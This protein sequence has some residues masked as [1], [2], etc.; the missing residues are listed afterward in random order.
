[1]IAV[2]SPHLD[3]GVFSCGALLAARPGSVVVTA[4][5]GRRGVALPPKWE[6]VTPWDAACGFAPGDDVIAARRAEDREA[7]SIL[8]ASPVWLD[9]PDAQYG[10]SPSPAALCRALDRVG[11]ASRNAPGRARRRG[12]GGRASRARGAG[13]DNI[14]RRAAC[15][16]GS[17][18]GRR[19]PRGSG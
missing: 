16:R 5:A 12:R 17:R 14:A 19:S 7:L 2:V 8:G 6:G 10:P 4:L 9:F 11:R 13:I 18:A 1:M 15:V 3:D